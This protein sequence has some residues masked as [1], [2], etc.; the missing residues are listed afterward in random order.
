[1]SYNSQVKRSS[2]CKDSVWLFYLIVFLL[3]HSFP[4][5]IKFY[6]ILS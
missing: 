3:Y 2:D 4:S 6:L 1:M 5:E